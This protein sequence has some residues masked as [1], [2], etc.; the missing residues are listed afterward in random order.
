MQLRWLSRFL[1]SV[2]SGQL[3]APTLNVRSYMANY[4]ISLNAYSAL[5]YGRKKFKQNFTDNPD[6]MPST[7]IIMNP[8]DEFIS[9]PLTQ[10]LFSPHSQIQLEPISNRDSMLKGRI[11]HLIIDRASLGEA[12]WQSLTDL[13]REFLDTPP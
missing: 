4:G 9:W 5:N 1:T 13:V 11:Q 6:L 7:L 10:E 3:I 2:V 8:E 12:S